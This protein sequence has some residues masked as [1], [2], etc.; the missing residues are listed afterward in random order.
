MPCSARAAMR[1]PGFGAM[2]HS[3]EAA[4]NHTT[5]SRKIFRRP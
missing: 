5:P 2:P 1:I 3:R 4:A